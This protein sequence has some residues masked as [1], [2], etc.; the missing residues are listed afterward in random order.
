ME[1]YLM[2]QKAVWS[3]S[4]LFGFV[5]LERLLQ[6]T[7][8]NVLVCFDKRQFNLLLNRTND[9]ETC[10]G[11][12]LQVNLVHVPRKRLQIRIVRLEKLV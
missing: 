11:F 9:E 5:W 3:K 2:K 8:L 12:N 4:V 1:K 7:H 6:S 10:L